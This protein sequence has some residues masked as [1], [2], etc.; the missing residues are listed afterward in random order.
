MTVELVIAARGGPDAKSR[1]APPL[2]PPDRAELT[3]RM[4]EDMLAAV[5]GAHGISRLWVVTP[6]AAIAE[7]A[8]SLGATLLRQPEPATLNGAFRAALAAIGETATV[9][10]LPGDLPLLAA[11]DLEQAIALSQSHAI[12][13]ARSTDGGTGALLRAGDVRFDPDFGGASFER[14][15]AQAAR[16]G[17]SLAVLQAASLSLDLDGPEDFATVLAQAPGSRTAAF[18]RE[19]APLR[20]PS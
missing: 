1:C 13:L 4:L 7:L 5:R 9:A 2:S 8:E 3:G 6:T 15:A 11:D 10:L 20:I 18:L 19:R 17:L 12:V 16:R 14:H